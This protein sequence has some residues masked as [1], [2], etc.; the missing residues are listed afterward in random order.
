MYNK[1]NSLS[2]RLS[3][4]PQSA[5]KM[6]F[7]IADK[8][9]RDAVGDKSALSIKGASSRGNVVQVSGLVRGTSAADVEVGPSP[10][11]PL[12]T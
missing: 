6:N 8:A 3:N 5:P 9:L 12:F 1:S 10:P 7:G 2:A 11:I 4:A